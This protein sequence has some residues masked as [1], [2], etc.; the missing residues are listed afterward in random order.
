MKIAITGGTGFMGRHLAAR[1]LDEDHGVVMASR[2]PNRTELDILDREGARFV[3]ANVTDPD[4]LRT[5]FENCDTVAHL[6]G[7]NL[8]RGDQTYRTVH[9]DGTRNV[10]AAA[11]DCDVT[12]LVL[13]SFL[14]ARPGC[15]FAYHESKWA[16]EEIVRE[17]GL[18]YTIL[19]PGITYGQGDQ[20]LEHLSRW[21]L[22]VPVFGR[23]G[24]QERPLRPLAIEDLVDVLVASV[25]EPRLS[26][27]TVPVLGPEEL[28][29]SEAINRIGGVLDRNPILIPVPLVGHYLFARVQRQVMHEPIT[30]P[31]QVRMLAEGLT[32]PLPMDV[33][34]PLPG[35]L[36]PSRPF[37]AEQIR[38]G[39]S[40]PEPYSLDDLRFGSHLGGG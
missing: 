13:S 22:T 7:I 6:A 4:S 40:D 5:A 21:L 17:S 19:K 27:T 23:V 18:E 38:R 2:G 16:A 24:F 30:S 15:G 11:E 34:T 28:S 31:A 35:D 36:T 3:A 33:C 32:E 1:L 12:R 29:L 10:A 9:I 26:G 25:T 14:R 20:M 39:L 37:S 8:E